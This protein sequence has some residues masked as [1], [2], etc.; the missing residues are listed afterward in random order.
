MSLTFSDVK[1]IVE[2]VGAILVICGFIIKINKDRDAV[3]KKIESN[4]ESAKDLAD[5]KIV[6]A[7][8][9]AAKE[10]QKAKDELDAKRGRIYERIDEIKSLHNVGITS[11][12]QEIKDNF[13]DIRLCKIVHEN[14]DRIFTEIRIELADLKKSIDRLFDKLSEQGQ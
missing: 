6:E 4:V 1:L 7:K 12:R 14:T 8:E 3:L 5:K 11:I 10:L 13:V 2:I 9:E